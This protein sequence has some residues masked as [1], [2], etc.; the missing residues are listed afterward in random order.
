MKTKIMKKYFLF[1]AIVML[2]SCKE[3]PLENNIYFEDPQ[4]INDSELAKIPSKFIGEYLNDD[5]LK[6]NITDEII[7]YTNN[8]KISIHKSELDSLKDEL[9]YKDG[10]FIEKKT[11]TVLENKIFGDSIEF[12][13]KDVDTVFKFSD[14]QKAKRING[15][16]IL[17]KKDSLYWQIEILTLNKNV[18]TIEE[19]RADSDIMAI[20]SLT[21]I[22]AKEIDRNNYIVK[23]SR[24]E[25]S[26]ILK[27]KKLG[28]SSTFRKIK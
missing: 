21:K 13:I 14:F 11:N 19:L 23:P 5:S 12:N 28:Y 17:S 20:D 25:F 9:V 1:L 3:V 6:L 8:F 4:P 7:S 15:K 24:K 10:K 2:V 22:K 16:L 27:L 26:K 18:I